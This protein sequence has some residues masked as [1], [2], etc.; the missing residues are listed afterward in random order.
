MTT[1]L[2]L[3]LPLFYPGVPIP[4]SPFEWVENDE[5]SLLSN[6]LLEEDLLTPVLE[7]HSVKGAPTT[8]SYLA[9]NPKILVYSFLPLVQTISYVIR[10]ALSPQAYQLV[11]IPTL[12]LA[13]LLWSNRTLPIPR[14]AMIMIMWN[15]H[16]AANTEFLVEFKD[17]VAFHKQQLVILT[18][19]KLSVHELISFSAN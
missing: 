6:E 12:N 10:N 2:Q 11:L 8:N 5:A 1:P 3:P 4:L 7:L 18:E 19:T 13:H 14:D 17:T 16:G 9:Q 15:C